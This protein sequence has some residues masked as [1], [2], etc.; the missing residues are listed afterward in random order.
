MTKRPSANIWLDVGM[1]AWTLGLDCAAVIGLRMAKLSQGGAPA[2]K[3][4]Q[5]M[6]TEKAES[7]VHLQAAMMTGSMGQTPDVFTDNLLRYLGGR[8]DANRKRLSSS[9]SR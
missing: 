4:A 6:V 9:K 5:R 8:V 1:D 3:E 7:L 2:L